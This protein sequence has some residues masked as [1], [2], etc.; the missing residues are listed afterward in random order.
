MAMVKN[1]NESIHVRL[2]EA[3]KEA[4]DELVDKLGR[5]AAQ[6]AREALKK[7]IAE[8]QKA[9]LVVEPATV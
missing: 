4:L 5:P 1:K 9:Q 7:E 8:L 6:I 2:T 3:D